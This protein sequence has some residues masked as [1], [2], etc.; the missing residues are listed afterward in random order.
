MKP[1]YVQTALIVHRPDAT[2]NVF[3]ITFSSRQRLDVEKK[4]F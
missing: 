2:R 4:Q 1:V 3:C